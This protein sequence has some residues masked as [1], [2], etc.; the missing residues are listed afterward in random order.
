MGQPKYFIQLSYLFGNFSRLNSH[1][2]KTIEILDCFLNC[3]NL[4][5]Y[6]RI[7]S[8]QR[9]LDG[10]KWQNNHR[11]NLSIFLTS[12]VTSTM[13]GLISG[14][15]SLQMRASCNIHFNCCNTDPP[16]PARIAGSKSSFMVNFLMSSSKSSTSKYSVRNR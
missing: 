13:V 7:D 2:C 15:F 6:S 5:V 9:N 11:M 3:A 10:G 16:S 8:L 14:S 12:F 1:K 4:K